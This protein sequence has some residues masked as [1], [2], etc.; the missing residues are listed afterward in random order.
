LILIYDVPKELALA[1]LVVGSEELAL[2]VTLEPPTAI[3]AE[4][5]RVSVDV[6]AAG[7]GKIAWVAAPK[8]QVRAGDPIAK[9]DEHAKWEKTLAHDAGRL[10]HYQAALAAARAK[11]DAKAIRHAEAKVAEK[12]ALVAKAKAGMA[13]QTI[14]AP[15]DGE[16]T[17]VLVKPR[18]K[19]K[20]GETVARVG[21]AT[22]AATFSLGG[23][24]RRWTAGAACEVAP[25]D[26][27]SRR[28]GCRIDRVDGGTVVV[29]IDEGSTLAVGATVVLLAAGRQP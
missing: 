15:A 23:G 7:K 5:A 27:R 2:R 9:L 19:V 6:Q 13:A 29:R 11:N 18:A 14:A 22:L 12:E 28:S 3:V 25:A 17:E 1:S 24:A 26:A 4:G 16:L 21:R 20:A 10:E 8:S